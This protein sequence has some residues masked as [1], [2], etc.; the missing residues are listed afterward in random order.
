MSQSSY[1]FPSSCPNVIDA[2]ILY[3]KLKGEDLLTPC[4]NV[5]PTDMPFEF[6]RA[7]LSNS[8]CSLNN[9]QEGTS[10]VGMNLENPGF[11]HG[12]FI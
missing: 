8:T 3:G 2:T 7:S 11:S 10:S 6:K 12:Q 5:I 4:I 1:Y 9:R